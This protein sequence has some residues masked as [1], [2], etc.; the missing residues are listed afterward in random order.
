MDETALAKGRQDNPLARV[1]V[2]DKDGAIKSVYCKVCASPHRAAAETMF[3]ADQKIQ[4]IQKFFEQQGEVHPLSGLRH[5]FN[6]HYRNMAEQIAI[7][8]YR[9]NLDAMMQRRRDMVNDMVYSINIAW[10]ELASILAIETDGDICK[11]QKKQ[12]MISDLQKTIKDGYEFIKSLNDGDAKM[13]AMEE[14]LVR[15]WQD[16][17]AAAKTEEERLLILSTMKDFKEKYNQL[18]M[19]AP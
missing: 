11:L 2:A 12:R 18:T 17:L 13:K 19:E 8:E 5:H 9:D 3:E 7:M 4:D 14:R 16:K 15:V 1:I 10:V 6:S